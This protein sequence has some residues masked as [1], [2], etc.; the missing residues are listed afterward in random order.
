VPIIFDASSMI[1]HAGKDLAI[2]IP[3]LR[4]AEEDV[5]LGSDDEDDD[6]LG[7]RPVSSRAGS[8]FLL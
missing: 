8:C 4:S 1:I 6:A 5:D 2:A 3:V 7:S